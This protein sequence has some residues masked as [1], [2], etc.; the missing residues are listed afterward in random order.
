MNKSMKF[1][2]QWWDEDGALFII[3]VKQKD[4]WLYSHFP[5]RVIQIKEG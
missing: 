2:L 1:K 3:W 4:L 5:Y